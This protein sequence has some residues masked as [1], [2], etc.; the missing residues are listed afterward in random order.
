MGLLTGIVI[1]LLTG[2]TMGLLTKSIKREKGIKVRK[3][4]SLLQQ[5]SKGSVDPYG[6]GVPHNTERNRRLNRQKSTRQIIEETRTKNAQGKPTYQ[7]RRE[8]ER[9]LSS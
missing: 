1:G 3:K 5:L 2:I 4:P 7:L 9:R 6:W 8:L